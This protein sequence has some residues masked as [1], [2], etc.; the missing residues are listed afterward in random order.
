MKYLFVFLLLPCLVL[1]YAVPVSA[2][3]TSAP[4]LSPSLSWTPVTS[5]NNLVTVQT[6]IYSGTLYVGALSGNYKEFPGG[7]ATGVSVGSSFPLLTLDL[8]GLTSAVGLYSAGNVNVS[9]RC[10]PQ[11]TFRDGSASYRLTDPSATVDLMYGY[12]E[13]SGFSASGRYIDSTSS[14]SLTD[15]VGY[16]PSH[17]SNWSAS[18]F[19]WEFHYS[20]PS[21][22]PINA[23]SM[24][25][26][27]PIIVQIS[28]TPDAVKP[29]I[30]GT[31]SGD[32]IWDGLEL[33]NVVSNHNPLLN[34]NP[35]VSGEGTTFI[36]NI[37]GLSRS[38]PWIQSTLIISATW[39]IV[40]LV[41][42]RK[43]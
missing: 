27:C 3:S 14:G 32:S 4:V 26:S 31:V 20:L 17:S 6:T 11:I 12:Q 10:I 9:V 8:G 29:Y 38:L 5:S 33:D 35:D 30:T 22:L 43:H 16:L 37:I 21:D 40:A 25:I 36:T 1:A 39:V 41:L 2:A 15:V 42:W 19:F 7:S 18:Y 28:G 34:L 13:T 24:D 23:R